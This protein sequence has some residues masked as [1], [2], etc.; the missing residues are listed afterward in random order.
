MVW[1]AAILAMAL[2]STLLRATRLLTPLAV[3]AL[4]YIAASLR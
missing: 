3:A 2:L 1:F 4:L